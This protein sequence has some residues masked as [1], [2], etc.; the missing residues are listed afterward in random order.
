MKYVTVMKLNDML[1]GGP[2]SVTVDNLYLYHCYTQYVLL[3]FLAEVPRPMGLCF[4][5]RSV[6]QDLKLIKFW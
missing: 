2:L 6:V 1:S 4:T 3:Y 5:G